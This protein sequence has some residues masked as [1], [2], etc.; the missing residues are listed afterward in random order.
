MVGKVGAV[1][2]LSEALFEG[3]SQ[4]RNGLA[5]REDHRQFIV[6]QFKFVRVIAL[7]KRVA[8]LLWIVRDVVDRINDSQV[9]ESS[10][11]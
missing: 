7:D 6:A 11:F 8:P 3:F 2:E 10:P 5:G 9:A 4:V 1:N